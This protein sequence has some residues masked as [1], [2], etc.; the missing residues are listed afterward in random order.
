MDA[1]VAATVV[2]A[3]ATAA[4]AG[5][6][7][8]RIHAQT[9]GGNFVR[10]CVKLARAMLHKIKFLFLS[11]PR[12]YWLM[13]AGL[14]L[15]TAGGSMIWPFL[16]IY[17]SG[18]LNLPLSTV[19][20]LI[21]INAG[22]GLLSSFLAGTLADKI[23]R[24]FVMNL[25]LTITGFAYF[26]LM[27]AETYPQFALLMVII[28]LSNPLYQVGADAMLADI[29][30]SE[31]RTDAY[32]INRIANNAAFALGPAVGGFLATRS[33]D[34]AFYGATAG[35]L[36]YSVLLFFMAH[37]TLDKTDENQGQRADEQTDLY[38]NKNDGYRQVFRDGDY[39]AFVLAIALGL[40]A[41]TMLWILMPIYT[42]TNFGLLESQYGWIPTTNA[43]MCV[44]VQYFVTTITRKHRA[45]PVAAVGMLIYALGA[46]SVALMSGFWGFW[47]SMVILTF[48]ELTLV[49]ISSKYVADRAPAHLRGRYMSVYWIG[50][51]LARAASPLI[52]GFLNDAIAP[53]AI[54]IG[55]LTL[56]LIST[57]VLFL[58]ASR[59]RRLESA[60][61]LADV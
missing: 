43:V 29:I 57:F 24:K 1:A 17:A 60:P 40:I 46:G 14:I 19:A 53:R 36:A 26:F 59:E 42:K 4:D 41:P 2:D 21:S 7:S 58:L 45:L 3:A 48:G 56:G 44:F 9:D 51:G 10:F 61:L 37:E 25:S 32:A 54:W 22:T 12:Q 38:E 11:Y 16:L 23:G 55:G 13:I 20:T 35:F 8:Y 50:W 18:K 6:H 49:P 34:F 39:M 27:R 5:N 52:G 15:A 31:K 28:G 47:L 33:Y 30:P